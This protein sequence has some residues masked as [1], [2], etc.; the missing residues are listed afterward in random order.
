MACLS[1]ENGL[2]SK[3]YEDFF[4]EIQNFLNILKK[5]LKQDL[6]NSERHS[7][8]V[9]AINPKIITQNEKIVRPGSR[10]HNGFSGCLPREES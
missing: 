4:A 6:H 1:Y 2:C 7:N 9:T 3:Y 10:R 5:T 8:F